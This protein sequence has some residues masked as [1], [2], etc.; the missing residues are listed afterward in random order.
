MVSYWKTRKVT[1]VAIFQILKKWRGCSKILAGRDGKIM[2]ST[3]NVK[4][5]K[6]LGKG[7]HFFI[8]LPYD[9]GQMIF[10]FNLR[11]QTFFSSPQR[12]VQIVCHVILNSTTPL[13]LDYK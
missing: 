9:G 13:L 10:I 5:L 2:D 6:D 12:G 1:G 7:R 11:G 3:E 4:S 8:N